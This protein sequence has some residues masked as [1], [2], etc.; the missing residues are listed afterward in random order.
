[1]AKNKNKEIIFLHS[2]GIKQKEIAKQ[3]G[4]TQPAVSLCLKRQSIKTRMRHPIEIQEKI[5]EHEDYIYKNFPSDNCN[6][7]QAMI[8]ALKWVLR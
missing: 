8:Q 3:L 4:I 7:R 5:K 6:Y 1:M 2:K